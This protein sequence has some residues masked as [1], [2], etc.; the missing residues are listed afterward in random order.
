MY[1]RKCIFCTATLQDDDDDDCGDGNNE[2]D[3]D[4][5]CFP[6]AIFQFGLILF[7]VV[8]YQDLLQGETAI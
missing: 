7:K 4:K 5:N 6:S 2:D 1:P 3:D 8:I